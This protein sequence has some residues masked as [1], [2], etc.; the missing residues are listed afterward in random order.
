MSALEVLK[1][2]PTQRKEFLSSLGVVDPSN[3]RLIMFD[4]DQGEPRIP[5]SIAFQVSISIQNL[6]IHRCI[7]NEGASTCVMSTFVWQ[8]LGSPTLQSSTTTLRAYDGR[9]TK[10]QGILLNVPISLASKTVLIEIDI[11]NT[12][13]DYNL[14]L[15][16]SYM[17]A[18][19]V[20]AST[21]F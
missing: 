9:S 20:M 11:I 8:K 17:Y 3:S 5:S 12:Q 16:R 15:G 21:V 13:L 14:L 18:M 7:I 4:L 2:F 1:T 19:R 10:A 6:V